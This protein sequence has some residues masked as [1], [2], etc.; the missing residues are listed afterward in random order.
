MASARRVDVDNGDGVADG[1][2]HRR[3]SIG[4][5]Q[6]VWPIEGRL[7]ANGTGHYVDNDDGMVR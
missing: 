1:E 2:I 3:K 6:S 7:I 5:R 4:S